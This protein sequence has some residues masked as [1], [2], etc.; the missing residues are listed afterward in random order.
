MIDIRLIGIG[1]GNPDH[2]T[3][4]AIKF[5]EKSDLILMPKKKGFGK[6]TLLDLRSFIFSNFLKNNRPFTQEFHMPER[7]KNISNYLERVKKWHSEIAQKWL[8]EINNFKN[9][10]NKSNLKIAL[11]I[12]GDP[13]LYDSSIRIFSHLKESH[14]NYS[15]KVIPGITAIQALTSA[16][17]I[18]I[19]SVG[20]EF[21][22]TTG[23]GLRSKGW[24]NSIDTVIV[25]LDDRCSFN[26]LDSVD[27]FIYWGAYLGMQEEL[28]FSGKINQVGSQIADARASAREKYGWIMDTYL[29]RKS[30]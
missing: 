25:M 13:S 18:P 1:T 20:K 4:E 21:L 10:S 23:R 26:F 9:K 19:N 17:Q 12:W 7:D 14:Q 11:M 16:H 15:L 28:L 5:L 8:N 29:L 3:L 27:T 2:I 24:P 30:S 22:I 6:K